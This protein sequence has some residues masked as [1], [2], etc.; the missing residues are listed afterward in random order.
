MPLAGAVGRL[1]GYARSGEL[2]APGNFQG[3]DQANHL[4]KP[5]RFSRWARIE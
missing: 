5:V 2:F 1:I 4:G 3:F